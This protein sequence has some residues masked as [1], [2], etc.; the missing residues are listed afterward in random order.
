MVDQSTKPRITAR[1]LLIGERIDTAGLERDDVLSTT[2]LAFRVGSDGFAAIFRYGVVVLIGLTPVEEDEIVRGLKPRLAGELAHPE[3]E[4][5]IIEMSA[6]RDEQVPPGG[7]IFVRTLS[8]ER[9]LIIADV[10]AKSA[11]LARD[12]RAVDSVIDVLEPFAHSLA[13]RGEAV[14]GRPTMRHIGRALEVR[15]RVT[16]RVA[17]AE[18]PDALWDR[19]DLTRLYARLEDEY[20]LVERAEALNRKLAVIGETATALT[21]LKDAE[22]SLRLEIIIV[23]LIAF[24][25]LVTIY[26]LARGVTH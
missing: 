7:P 23:L 8:P 26:N 15:L 1:A 19:P 12:E 14:G 13:E 9:L 22:R 10:L 2:P 16:G 18:K 17:V 5:A 24:E 6:D 4:T 21:D 11:V 25:V 20:E 3:E